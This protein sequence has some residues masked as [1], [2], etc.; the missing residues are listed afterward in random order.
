MQRAYELLTNF[1]TIIAKT[2]KELF[3]VQRKQ[4]FFTQYITVIYKKIEFN[5]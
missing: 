3:P 5:T 4:L 2:E 1:I